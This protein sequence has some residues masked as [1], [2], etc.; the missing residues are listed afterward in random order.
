MKD[1]CLSTYIKIMQSGFKVHD[2]QESATRFLL[3]S[4]NEQEW[5]GR[6]GYRTDN[7]TSKKIS[8]IVNRQ[9]PVPDAIKQASTITCVIDNVIVYFRDKVMDDFNPHLKDETLTKLSN[10]V[11][12]DAT[13]PCV[14]KDN[15]LEILK[16]GDSALF[17]AELFLY[18]LNRPNKIT[19][20]PIDSD[21]VP[22]LAEADYECPISH[23]KL[24]ET[25]KG[26]PVKRY[27][28]TTI[29]PAGLDKAEVDAFSAVRKAPARL[30][31]PENLIALHEAE[32]ERYLMRPTVD[33]YKKLCAVKEMISR[34]YKARISVDAVELE[35]NIRIVLDALSCLQDEADLSDMEYEALHVEEKFSSENFILKNEAQMQVVAYYRYIESVFAESV[36]DFDLITNEIRVSSKKL[37]NAGLSQGEVIEHLSE[38]IRNKAGLDESSKTACNIVVSFFIQNCAVFDKHSKEDS[39]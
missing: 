2:K 22:L 12:N 14:K 19:D 36:D 34:R 30:D 6:N 8:R 21:D 35:E 11:E 38:W 5:V 29:F 13:I 24:V 33:E 3:N 7:L 4:V 15:L 1:L 20:V 23:K 32:A 26:K 16:D 31:V 37:E 10:L 25:I 39:R 28:I 17:L 9:D 27:R 18:A